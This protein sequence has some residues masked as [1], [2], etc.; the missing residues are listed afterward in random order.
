LSDVP[1][2]ASVG[3]PG[4]A[5]LKA[6][7]AAVYEQDWLSLLL[8][9]SYHPG[10]VGLT[11][12][13]ARALGLRPGMRVLDVASGTGA[14][15]ALLAR[16][17]GVDV[18]GIDRSPALVAAATRRAAEAGLADRV[19]FVVGDGEE[20]PLAS[21]CFDAVVCECA[22]CT[23]PDKETGAAQMA[24]ILRPGG[25]V[26][27]TDMT[28]D[29]GRLDPDLMSLTGWVAC[30]AGAC[31]PG[32]YASLLEDTGLRVLRTEDHR[33]ALLD[34][35]QRV[36]ARLLTLVSLRLPAIP[37]IDPGAVRRW[38]GVA[39]RTVASGAVGYSLLTAEKANRSDL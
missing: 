5:E 23:F 25:R 10:D 38:M 35:L 11:R 6:C 7:C 17:H 36:E 31:S 26:G 13:L 22:F 4:P 9:G 28:V 30:L 27:I 21:G 15:A 32:G 18:V 1:D 16:E 3:I 33:G 20:L 37:A 24:R 14:T 39:R 29:R 8:G 2:F 12:R 34:L 19:S